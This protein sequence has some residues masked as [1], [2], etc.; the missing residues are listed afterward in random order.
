MDLTYKIVRRLLRDDDVGFSRNQNF[1]AYEDPK[2]KRAVRIYRHLQSVEED[3]LEVSP[4]GGV[5][6]DAVEREEDRVV[7]R[8]VFADGGGRRVSFMTP[9]EWALLLENER[10]TDILRGLMDRATKD[11]RESIASVVPEVDSL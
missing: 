8:L 2:V 1:E 7:V 5:E 3:L 6:L 9:R 10:V 4:D 11:T